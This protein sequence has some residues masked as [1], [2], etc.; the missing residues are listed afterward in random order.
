MLAKVTKILRLKILQPEAGIIANDSLR[1]ALQLGLFLSPGRRGYPGDHSD[2]VIVVFQN[3]VKMWV[4][5]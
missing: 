2:G 5:A 4:T 3:G 1:Y